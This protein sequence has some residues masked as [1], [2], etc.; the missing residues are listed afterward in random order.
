MM[1]TSSAMPPNCSGGIT[2]RSALT[3][4]SVTTKSTSATIMNQRGGL[5]WREKDWIISMTMRA[6]KTHE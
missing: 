2:F 6:N 4:G 5:N 1:E 3:G